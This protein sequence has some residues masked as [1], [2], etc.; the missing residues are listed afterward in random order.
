MDLIGF[1]ASSSGT[2]LA[3]LKI[4]SSGKK[5]ACV[6]S[7]YFCSLLFKKL[8][9]PEANNII[10]L[11]TGLV[12]LRN[13]GGAS[14]K[15]VVSWRS[16]VGSVNNSVSSLLNVEDMTNTI[17]EKTS[18]A[19]S[20]ENNNINKVT[21]RKT[22]TQTY[23]LDNPP[24][25]SV[26]EHIND[27]DKVLKLF[28]YVVVG[29]NQLP[30]VR[31]CI[32]NRHDFEP[33][34][35]FML[36]IELFAVLSKTISDKLIATKELAIGEKI[37]VNDDVRQINKCSDW[38]IVVKE[39]SVDFSKLTV[40]SVFSKFSKVVFIKIQ[41]IGLWQ[42]ALMKYESSEI[43]DLVAARLSVFMEKNSVCVAKT[44]SD[45]QIWVSRNQHQTLLH[46]LLVGTIAYNL[47]DLLVSYDK[48]TCFIGYDPNSYVYDRC[49]IVCFENKTFLLT[50]IS[51]TLVFKSVN[52]CWA[53][54]FL[55]CC[56]QYIQ[57][58]HI[59]VDCTVDENSGSHGKWMAPIACPVS[60]VSNPLSNPCLV[61]CLA[62]L[63]CFL[64]LLS[65][66]VSIIMKKLSFVELV[67]LTNMSY[68][69][70]PITQAFLASNLD[71]NMVLDNMLTSPA[72]S[73]LIIVDIFADFNS[74]SS[75]IL[76]T[77]VGGLESKMV[78]L[79]VLVESVLERLDCLCSGL[80]LLALLT[81]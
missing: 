39:I 76:T 38:E 3:G 54:L 44:I 59:S 2:D 52:L 34:K 55:A 78:G 5:K 40:E 68:V 53:G 13:I 17:A 37:L 9:K 7:V 57:F 28:P 67:L 25:Q 11:F 12:N 62:S 46:T 65:D 66:Q 21:L 14:I 70:P 73:L 63:K 64:E 75:K 29:S 19:E 81:S 58:G 71:L 56:A 36:D 69:F 61:D 20:D 15:F 47:S 41:L 51:S 72:P 10:D 35:F 23:M 30:T 16:E 43:A 1:S 50:I 49:A 80:G 48:K 22:Y 79:K 6:N 18:Y 60:F 8:K 77:K 26:F 4:W 32:L 45:K 74:S 33:V 31:L 42:K 24:K 27:D